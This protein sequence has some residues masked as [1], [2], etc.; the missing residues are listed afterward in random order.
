MIFQISQNRSIVSMNIQKYVVDSNGNR[1]FIVDQEDLCWLM[2]FAR[3]QFA[4]NIDAFEFAPEISNLFNLQMK[5]ID[6]AFIKIGSDSLT[7]VTINE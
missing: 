6:D 5:A 3:K 1:Q 4:D 2:G 7:E